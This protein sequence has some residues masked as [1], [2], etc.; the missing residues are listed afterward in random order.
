MKMIMEWLMAFKKNG[1]SLIVSLIG[2]PQHWY[3]WEVWSETQPIYYNIQSFV[4]PN[5]L[6][7]RLNMSYPYTESIQI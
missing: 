2:Q 6:D 4:C 5:R 3:V 1:Y 7:V